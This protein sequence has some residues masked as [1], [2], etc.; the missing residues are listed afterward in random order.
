MRYYIDTCIWIDY[1]EN[2][3]ETDI[4]VD[5]MMRQ[6]TIVI[7]NILLKEIINHVHHEKVRMIFQM[8]ESYMLLEHAKTTT[9]QDE[10]ALKLSGERLVPKPDALHA[11][12]ARDS[13]AT[14]ITR[15]KHFLQLQ[16]ICTIK[17][18]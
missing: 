9:E 2:R 14:L 18:L 10:E 11:I 1:L 12:I 3:T 17:L 6:D 5:C 15:D 7:S 16:D 8:L 4:F 13:D